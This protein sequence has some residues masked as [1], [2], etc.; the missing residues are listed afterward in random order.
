[1]VDHHNLTRR[2]PTLNQRDLAD[3]RAAVAAHPNYSGNVGSSY[4]RNGIPRR[5][6]EVEY[7]KTMPF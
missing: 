3:L 6:V 7:F 1:V 4:H 5:R 2:R